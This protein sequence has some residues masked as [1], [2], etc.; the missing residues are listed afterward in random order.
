MNPPALTLRLSPCLEGRYTFIDLQGAMLT[1]TI[2]P[3][4]LRIL[5]KLLCAWNI[6]PVD[7]VLCAD[8]TKAGTC[9]REIW[10]EALSYVR[11]R[12]VYQ[13]RFA[14]YRGRPGGEEEDAHVF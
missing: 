2:E 6:V 7:V 5:L 14:P 13:L 8:G 11:G 9:W 3:K 4:K 10:E 1:L 12:H